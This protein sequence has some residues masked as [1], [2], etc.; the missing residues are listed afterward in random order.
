MDGVVLLLLIV[1]PI[2]FIISV[3]GIFNNGGL[4]CIDTSNIDNLNRVV[5]DNV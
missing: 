1:S 5:V 4:P 2:V 3:Y